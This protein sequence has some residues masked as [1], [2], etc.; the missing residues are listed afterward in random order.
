M[1]MLE[2]FGASRLRKLLGASLVAALLLVAAEARPAS[3][4]TGRVGGHR[5]NGGMCRDSFAATTRVEAPFMKSAT[6]GWQWVSYRP[7]L[8]RL[9]SSSFQWQRW[10]DGQE[11]FG[12]TSYYENRIGTA[13]QFGAPYFGGIYR[14]SIEYR[15]YT[16]NTVTGFDHLW[17]NSMYTP[18]SIGS[19]G[20]L[21]G[22]GSYGPY[23]IY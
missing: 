1:T 8:W 9:N 5:D 12:L 23:C 4:S 22:G 7:V 16:G 18:P 20:G 14:V 13:Y 2:K 21:A 19:Y 11:I 6:G 17:V 15:W 10:V 3:A